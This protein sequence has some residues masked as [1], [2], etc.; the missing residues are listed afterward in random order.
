MT[1]AQ[2]DLFIILDAVKWKTLACGLPSLSNKVEW[3]KLTINYR[4]FLLVLLARV[5]D[6]NSR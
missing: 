1:G 6:L 3:G 2:I 4:K 5:N